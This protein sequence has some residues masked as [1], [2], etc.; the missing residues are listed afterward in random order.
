MFVPFIDEESAFS[1]NLPE[2]KGQSI[3]LI[4]GAGVKR[5]GSR[6]LGFLQNLWADA[7]M[8]QFNPAF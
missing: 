3:Y 1:G 8:G 4:R 5:A 2:R 7:I 6:F